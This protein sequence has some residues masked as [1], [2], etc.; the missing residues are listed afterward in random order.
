MAA[1]KSASRAA[2]E[3]GSSVGRVRVAYVLMSHHSFS[4]RRAFRLL[5]SYSASGSTAPTTP[6]ARAAMM[7]VH[8]TTAAHKPPSPAAS[9]P[10]E[11]PAT[12]ALAP[13]A[14]RWPLWAL[15]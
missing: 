8:P 6:D 13:A 9:A 5:R 3:A 4:Y 10:P 7:T 14:T 15:V 12:T 11:L 2:I 1:L